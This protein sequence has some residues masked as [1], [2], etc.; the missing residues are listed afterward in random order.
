MTIPEKPLELD[1]EAAKLNLGATAFLD[2]EEWTDNAVH[3]ANMM[4]KFLIQ[5]STSWTKAEINELQFDELG[6]V[7]KQVVA[8]LQQAAVPLANSPS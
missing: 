8:A 6:E 4:R 3:A 5:H 7:A 1:Q 2:G